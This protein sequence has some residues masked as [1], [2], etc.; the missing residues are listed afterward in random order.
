[1]DSK[2]TANARTLLR[3]PLPAIPSDCRVVDAELR[4][5]ASSSVAGR[6]LSVQQVAASWT[7]S[8]VTWNNQ[9]TRTGPAATAVSATG[10]I[11][12]TVTD[13]VNAMYTGTNNGLMVR[14][15]V[16][17]GSGFQQ[18]FHSREKGTD[19]PPELVITFG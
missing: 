10:W 15:D 16:E 5:Y 11:E 1:V 9:P 2:A 6:T 13:Q 12:W 19:R 4:L 18:A 17:G 8:G 14:D 3:F 7:Q